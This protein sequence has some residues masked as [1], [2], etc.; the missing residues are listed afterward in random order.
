MIKNKNDLRFDINYF[1]RHNYKQKNTTTKERNKQKA[2]AHAED[3]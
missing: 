2:D 3:R 1:I